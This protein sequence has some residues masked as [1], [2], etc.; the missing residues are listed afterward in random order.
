MMRVLGL[1]LFGLAVAANSNLALAGPS[2]KHLMLINGH[3]AAPYAAWHDNAT[4]PNR[5]DQR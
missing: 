3:K 5:P 1:A 2:G 4:C